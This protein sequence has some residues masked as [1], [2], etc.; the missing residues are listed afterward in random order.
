MGRRNFILI[1]LLVLGLDQLSKWL[2]VNY[3][4]FQR[5]NCGWFD[6]N[7]VTNTGGAFGLFPRMAWLYTI[8]GIAVI[9]AV[10]FSL[11][12]IT[13]LPVLYQC[14]LALIT[15]GALGNIIDR[16]RFKYVIDFIDFRF[17][18]VFNLADAFICIGVIGLIILEL[19]KDMGNKTDA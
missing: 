18:P 15:G 16:L 6:L 13:A 11:N 2:T 9:L 3:L 10:F 14:C 1:T 12:K 8:V 17:W 5:I 4:T 7:Y 19:K